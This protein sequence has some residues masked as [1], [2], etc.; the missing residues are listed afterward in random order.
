MKDSTPPFEIRSH[1]LPRL[2]GAECAIDTTLNGKPNVTQEENICEL[3]RQNIKT[4]IQSRFRK[5]DTNL[6]HPDQLSDS[7]YVDDLLGENNAE[8]DKFQKALLE[9]YQNYIS[10]P[11]DFPVRIHSNSKDS[12]C[13]GCAL[14]K[15][16]L[17]EMDEDHY[18]K[19]F[20]KMAEKAG[21]T[22]IKIES[23]EKN[24]M[25]LMTSVGTLRA[26]M[27]FFLK[28]VRNPQ[29]LRPDDNKT[30]AFLWDYI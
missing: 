20:I 18:A 3:V 5:A 17:T 22:D 15:H 19:N 26:V 9:L 1:H 27:K 12:L 24:R 11:D 30:L 2:L 6:V 25:S 28:A 7:D 8:S 13:H 21:C 14:G 29:A 10:L 23:K 4:L 16:C